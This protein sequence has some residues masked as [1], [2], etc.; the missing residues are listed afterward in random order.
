MIQK[1]VCLLGATGV[2]KTSLVKKFVEGMFSERYLTTI[3]VKVDKKVV[4]TA[5]EQ[6]QLML[7]DIEGVDRYCGFQAKYLRGASAYLVVV[8]HTRSQ[9]LVEGL[10]I[11]RMA[12]EVSDAPAILVVNKTDLDEGW[13]WNEDEIAHHQLQF[14]NCFR[15]S[16]KTG[17]Q[18]EPLFSFI[19]EHL[20]HMG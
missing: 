2:G 19:A 13:H 10:E 11:H 7:W 9:S 12:R 4:A 18:V 20:L 15:T 14:L 6:V 8:D 16:A 17:D 3:G 5:S 1:K